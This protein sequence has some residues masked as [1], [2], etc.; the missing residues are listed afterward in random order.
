MKKICVSISLVFAALWLLPQVCMAAS[1]AQVLPKGTFRIDTTYYHYF[2]ID[3]IYNEN[4]DEE[5]LAYTYNANLNSFVFPTL[6]ALDPFIP[7]GASIGN[8]VVDF[9]RIYRWWEFNFNYGLTDKISV[10]VRL[11]YNMNRNEVDASVDNTTAN[12][13]KNPCVNADANPS[14]QC[15]AAVGFLPAL[16]PGASYTN[17]TMP[18]LPIT[19]Q[20]AF[21][22]VG[23]GTDHRLTTDDVQGLLGQGIDVDGDNVIDIGGYGYDPMVTWDESGI[24]DTE[25]IVR[26]QYYNSKPWILAVTGGTRL[27]TGEVKNQDSLVDLGFGNGQADIFLNFTADYTGIDRFYLS[28]TVNFNVQLP[29]E[30]VLRIPLD[31]NSPP[32]TVNKENVDRDLGDS[33]E[34]ELNGTYSI[35]DEIGINLMYLF[36][37]KWEDEIDGD[38]GFNYSSLED[39]TDSESHIATISLGYSTFKKYFAKEFPIPLYANIAYR[40]RFAGKNSVT[41]SEY[42]SFNFGFLF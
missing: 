8:S 21:T 33:V 19:T 10:G 32:I 25:L 36:M 5:P 3:D 4:G 1:S 14:A 38:M 23:L 13:I 22:A 11:Y 15:T 37:K 6:G 20:P 18:M 28:G 26:Y 16:P 12:V 9:T 40:N 42:V 34:I 27:P 30:E 39:E 7:G 2:D 24:G 35:T 17:G 41:K 29:D 31:V